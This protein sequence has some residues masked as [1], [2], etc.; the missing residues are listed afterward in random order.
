MKPVYIVIQMSV[1]NVFLIKVKTPWIP[2][3]AYVIICFKIV[4]V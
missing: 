1:P 2:K 4:L 3:N